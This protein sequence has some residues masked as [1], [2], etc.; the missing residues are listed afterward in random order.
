MTSSINQG[1]CDIDN[2]VFFIKS[3]SN[4]KR[5]CLKFKINLEDLICYFK[6][7]L[8]NHFGFEGDCDFDEHSVDG[9]CNV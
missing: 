1:Q 4:I 6:D 3:K 9:R 5:V 8:D 7:V 2:D